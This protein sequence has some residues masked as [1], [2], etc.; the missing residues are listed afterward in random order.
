MNIY[1]Q[2]DTGE[3]GGGVGVATIEKVDTKQKQRLTPRFKILLHNDDHNDMLHVVRS[4]MQVFKMEGEEAEKIMWEA[5]KSSVALCRIEV[6]EVAE[7]RKEQLEAFS[8][9]ATIEPE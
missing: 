6:Q 3:Q 2:A 8:L 4:L 7:L 9:I 1:C 5:H